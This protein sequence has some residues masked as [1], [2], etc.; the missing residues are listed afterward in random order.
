MK[1][2]KRG[3]LYTF[4]YHVW[5]QGHAATNFG[6]WRNATEPY[7]VGFVKFIRE[8]LSSLNINF[9]YFGNLISNPTSWFPNLHL[10]TIRDLLDLDG[11][12]FLT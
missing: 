5:T 9:R 4:R 2:L 8:S 6:L 3:I 12:K 11:I 7:E 10:N 1:F